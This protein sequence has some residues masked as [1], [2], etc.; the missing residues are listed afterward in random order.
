MFVFYWG[1][2]LFIVFFVV[3]WFLFLIVRIR[4]LM[5]FDLVCVVYCLVV[6]LVVVGFLFLYELFF[7]FCGYVGV[8]L[9]VWLFLVGV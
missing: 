4:F 5:F 1:L 3:F 7:L 2:L 9:E 8:F 6:V